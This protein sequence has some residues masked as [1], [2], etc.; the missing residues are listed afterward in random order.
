[1]ELEIVGRVT[2]GLFQYQAWPTVA[3]AADGTLY[4]ASSGHRLGHVCPF[5]KNYLYISRDEGKSWKGPVVA[6][7][8]C[9]DDRDA[10]LC[11]WGEGNVYLTWFDLPISHYETRAQDAQSHN[12]KMRTPLAQAAVEVWKSLPEEKMQPGGYARLSRDGGKSWSDIIKVPLT[13]PHGPTRTAQGTLLYVGKE[14]W[15]GQG[16]ETKAMYAMESRDDGLTWSVLSQLP[17]PE[18]F[19]WQQIHEAHGLQLTDGTTLAVLRV[20]DTALPG[21]ITI[22][23]TRSTD[24]CKTWSRPERMTDLL[25]APGHLMQHSSGA[26]VMTYGRRVD[27]K[28]QYARISRDSGLTWSED[29]PVSPEAPDGDHGYPSTVELSDG[30]LYTV[31]YQKYPG[32]DYASILAS[33]WTLPQL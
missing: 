19:A 33:R 14:C 32:D 11:L 1:M 27:R 21:G 22:Y 13:S 12:A 29:I 17:C 23:L 7:D 4:V 31:F 8:T 16:L 2:G 9:M 28:G 20:H 18:G 30:G 24:G 3:R 5:G 26:V 15:W 25:G 10:G 6:N